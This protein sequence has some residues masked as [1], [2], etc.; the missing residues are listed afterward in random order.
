M[1][2]VDSTPTICLFIPS[3]HISITYWRRGY[4]RTCP[5]QESIKTA[6]NGINKIPA[7]VSINQSNCKSSSTPRL[8]CTSCTTIPNIPVSTHFPLKRQDYCA[9]ILGTSKLPDWMGSE[10]AM[11]IRCQEDAKKMPV[12]CTACLSD[13]ALGSGS[14]VRRS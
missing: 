8:N 12:R 14:G 7:L 2:R 3:L 10:Y 6:K 11:P 9:K 13:N 5:C 4:I 1:N